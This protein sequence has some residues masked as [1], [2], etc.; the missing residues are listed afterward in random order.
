M[1]IESPD[2][3]NKNTDPDTESP[4]EELPSD[5]PSQFGTQSSQFQAATK[6]QR[7]Y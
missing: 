4:S 7:L 5:V 6:I 1:V 2:Q 3:S